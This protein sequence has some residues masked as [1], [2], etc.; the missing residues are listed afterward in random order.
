MG[1]CFGLRRTGPST[2]MLLGI[3]VWSQNHG[4]LF[5]S[6]R[7]VLSSGMLGAALDCAFWRLFCKRIPCARVRRCTVLGCVVVLGRGIC[8]TSLNATRAALRLR[9]LAVHSVAQ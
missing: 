8:A 9:F 4:V 5:L 2:Q 3:Q 7:V 1:G 6:I